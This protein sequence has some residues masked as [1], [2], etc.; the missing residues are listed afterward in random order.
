MWNE[1]T[2]GSQF[3]LTL[4]I[5]EIELRSLGSQAKPLY[6]LCQLTSSTLYFLIWYC[7]L[8]LH[9]FYFLVSNSIYKEKALLIN[10]RCKIFV[11]LFFIQ[12]IEYL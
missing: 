7:L 2:C 3:P 5:P 12:A 9:V 4:W 6:P 1:E 10:Y 8:S 11:V